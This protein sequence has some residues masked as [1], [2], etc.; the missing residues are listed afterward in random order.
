MD[1]YNL[2]AWHIDPPLKAV[3]LRKSFTVQNEDC[4]FKILAYQYLKGL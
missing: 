1:G 3:G 4:R 2:M